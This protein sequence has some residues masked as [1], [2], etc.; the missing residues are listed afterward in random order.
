MTEAV[1][2]GLIALLVSVAATPVARRLALA[3]GLTDAPGGRRIHLTPIPRAGGIAVVVAAVAACA[4]YAGM[5]SGMGVAVVAG[6]A[7]LLAVGLADD[8]LSLNPQVKLLGQL[9]AAVLA[10]LGGLRLSLLDPAG[11]GGAL[12]LADAALTVFWIVLITNAV[13]L[14]DG[15]DG[16]AAGVGTIA[17]GWLAC[18]ALQ[19]GD[20][21]AA[22][23]PMALAGALIGFLVY[24]FNP[25]SIFLGDTGSLVI[26]YAMAVLP[27]VGAGGSAMPPLAAAL[28]VAVPVTDTMLA[29]AR[30]FISRCV[31]AW[32]DGLFWRGLVD[33]LRNTVAPDRRHIHHRL[34]DLG[35]SQRRAVLLLYI[36]AATTG[37]L[38]YVVT[39]SPG[40]PVDLFAVGLGLG[41]IAIV[42]ALGFD[43]LQPVR[44]GLFLPLL[45]RLARHRWLVVVVDAC[46]VV[47]VYGSVLLL[48]GPGAS[49]GAM[50]AALGLMAVVQ[51]LTFAAR[52][53]YRTAWRATGISGVGGFGLLIRTCAVGAVGGYVVLRLF[54]LPTGLMLALCYFFLILSAVTLFR[55][56]YVL[57]SQAAENAAPAERTLICGTATGARHALARLQ[58]AGEMRLKPVGFVEFR[59]RW[60]GRR[61]DQLPVL[62]T[63]DTL[64]AILQEHEVR[65]LVV[66]DPAL[67][68][69]AFTWVRAVCRQ[70]GVRVHRYVE[71][72]VSHDE[73]LAELRRAAN[74]ADAWTVLGKVFGKMGIDECLLSISD[75]SGPWVEGGEGRHLYAWRR[76][77]DASPMMPDALTAC[78]RDDWRSM[79]AFLPSR[80]NGAVTGNGH[81][82]V[83][84]NGHTNGHGPGNGHGSASGNGPASPSTN[85]NGS[86]GGGPQASAA[87]SELSITPGPSVLRR[88]GDGWLRLASADPQAEDVLALPIRSGAT[89]W[90]MLLTTARAGDRLMTPTETER[91]RHIAEVLSRRVCRWNTARRNGAATAAAPAR[92]N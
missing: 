34:L 88:E 84:G 8:A 62:G 30:R 43:E 7:L 37:A 24:N 36:A 65:H 86:A 54:G 42:Q 6:G 15:L 71:K 29:I 4:A 38:S 47:A 49:L 61:L 82:L 45:R 32:A 60:Q 44:S 28:V 27:L 89:L 5:P 90:G 53:V 14:T 10:V 69:D 51:L 21:A 3:A 19:A 91:L 18:T 33:G 83:N 73:L 87:A 66:A 75:G 16:L 77:P 46:L 50:M 52:G 56:S 64:P 35:F 41:V 85:G 22:V 57:M 9:I 2:T 11:L 63:L 23:A 76:L 17:C 81:A 74:M 92:T 78:L 59:P 12:G 40:W 72:F 80:T 58:R 39:T 1:I 67:R 26:G 25:A 79:D 20:P 31:C 55:F 70:L 48:E 13:N 68:G